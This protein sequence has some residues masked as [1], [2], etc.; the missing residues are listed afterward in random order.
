[1]CLSGV[2]TGTSSLLLVF[3]VINF[4]VVLIKGRER[5]V[6]VVVVVGFSMY[7]YI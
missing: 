2:I 1:M 4:V 3:G 5:T 7:L 6:L